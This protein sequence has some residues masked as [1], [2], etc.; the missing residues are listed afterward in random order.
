MDIKKFISR[1]Y[2]RN[3]WSVL[4]PKEKKIFQIA[5]IFIIICSV[6]LAARWYLA[7][8][9]KVAKQGGDLREGL[10]GQPTSL[11]PILAQNDVDKDLSSLVF[12]GLVKSDGN[13]GIV[14]D[15]AESIEKSDDGKKWI[16]HLRQDVLWH[17]GE[18]FSADDVVFTI[19]AIKDPESRSSSTAWQGVEVQK[20]NEYTVVF[21]LKNP[22]SFFE[23]NLKQKIIPEHIF[24]AIPLANLY[25]SDYNF[26]PIGTGPFVFDKFEKSK[27]GFIN[28]YK[29]TANEK[30]F[31]G[32]SYINSYTVKL[33][34][35]EPEAVKAFNSRQ[36]DLYAGVNSNNL[37]NI[38][39]HYGEKDVSLARYYAVFF[40]Q[41]IS[42]V[43]ADKNVRYALNYATNR[44]ELIERVFDGK[45]KEVNGPILSD[46]NGYESGLNWEFSLEKANDILSKNGWKDS[47][48][49]GILEKKLSKDLDVL[50]LLS[51]RLIV[52]ESAGLI[53]TASILKDQW[54]KI[55]CRVEIQIVSA[56]ELQ[57]NYL[58]PRVYD[59][60]IF[61][62]M[63]NYNPDPFSFWHSSQKLSPGFNLALYENSGADK[64]LESLR[65][66]FDVEEQANDLKKFQS[67]VY[68]DAPAVFLFNP[69][70]IMVSLTNLDLNNMAKLNS[71]SDR[72]YDVNHWFLKTKRVFKSE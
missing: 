69:Y 71:L 49:D 35:S 28:Y 1:S 64:V 38:D 24:S 33:Y 46:M 55:G 66:T 21:E 10:V 2:W 68:S 9:V 5:A 53:E 15:L 72:Y 3:F 67:F 22:Y 8:T 52:P 70:Y 63:L 43:L 50:S 18:R 14:N 42:K 7:N 51:F 25:L 36:I 30:Y 11:N 6:F 37:E 61:G 44:Q 20:F 27:N 59:A 41:S 45:S 57:S 40:N 47:D 4:T 12:N 31:Q 23:E 62:N 17:D 34:Q 13:G 32:R 39:R 48:G 56:K 26:Q 54:A 19:K 58:E 65:Q 16:V 60:L 29:F